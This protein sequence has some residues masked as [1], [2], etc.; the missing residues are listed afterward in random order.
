[1][2]KSFKI[3]SISILLLSHIFVFSQTISD[4]KNVNGMSLCSVIIEG[5]TNLNNFYFT[6]NNVIENAIPFR[7]TIGPNSC[8]SEIIRFNIPVK[9]F[10]GSISDMQ[11]DF[12]ILLKDLLYPNISVGVERNLI[13]ILTHNFSTKEL[14]LH[15]TL[16]GITKIVKAKYSIRTH[17]ENKII[18]S[19]VTQFNLTDFYLDPPIKFFGIVKVKNL[20]SIK[21]DFALIKESKHYKST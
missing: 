15:I 2:D 21:F 10:K 4:S 17:A 20:V 16:A 19:G 3:V 9:A 13:L 7:E 14:Y 12:Q 5:S 11:N 6:Y 8:D 1:M 18:I